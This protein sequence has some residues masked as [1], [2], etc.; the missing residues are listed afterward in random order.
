MAGKKRSR[1]RRTGRRNRRQSFMGG[2]RQRFNAVMKGT[3]ELGQYLN[4]SL[5]DFLDLPQG[6]QLLPAS[7]TITLAVMHGPT[8][9]GISQWD[10]STDNSYFRCQ[11]VLAH[12]NVIRR[13]FHWPRNPMLI[14]KNT[15]NQVLVQVMHADV[16]G[17]AIYGMTTPIIL[18]MCSIWCY[19]AADELEVEPD[20]KH[21]SCSVKNGVDIGW[22]SIEDM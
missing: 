7:M 1:R 13:T 21:R 20:P 14:A 6:T 22:S 8:F 2:M 10:G 4:V 11:N 16:G 18:Y 9:M 15:S 12:R 3:I 17:K 5:S 19:E